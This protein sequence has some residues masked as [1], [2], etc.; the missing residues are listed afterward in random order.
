MYR[1]LDDLRDAGLVGLFIAGLAIRAVIRNR[2][3]QM[4][5]PAMGMVLFFGVAYG[6]SLF[7]AV[8]IELEYL[9]MG[10]QDLFRL[11]VRVLQFL[12]LPAIAYSLWI[13]RRTS[14]DGPLVDGCVHGV[15]VVLA[16]LWTTTALSTAPLPHRTAE[17][18][19][20]CRASDRAVC[21]RSRGL[22]TLLPHPG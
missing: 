19:S 22:A 4:L 7:G 21:D 17:C 5:Y 9:E 16:S 20:A 13:G 10:S 2:S 18:A 14:A 12:G 8:L 6:V 1:R 15:S 11:I 3:R